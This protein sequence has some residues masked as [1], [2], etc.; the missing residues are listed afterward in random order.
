M[1]GGLKFFPDQASTMAGP[2]DAFFFYLVGVSVFFTVLIFTLVAVFAVKYRRRPGNEQG[3]HIEGSKLLEI[4][5]TVIPL[6][7]VAIMFFW[8]AK[9]YYDQERAPANALDVLVTGK[10]WMWKFQ[11]SNGRREINTLHI[12]ARTPIKL[13]MGSED[14][15]HNVFVPAF[16]VK[17]DVV[18][19]RLT[20]VWFEATKTGS[21]HL[22]CNQ[23]CGKDHSRMVGK[24]I[25]MEPNEFQAWL[26]GDTGLPPVASGELLFNQL[27]CNSCH[28]GEG[29]LRGP[30]L[31]GLHGS[32][33]ALLGGGS[34]IADDDYIRESIVNPAAKIVDGY[35]PIMPT[36]KGL[37]TEEQLMHLVAYVKS[38][39]APS[40]AKAGA[41]ETTSGATLAV[42]AATTA[43]Q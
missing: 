38:L 40:G 1:Q 20:T 24:V 33:V 42:D 8:G 10:K 13:T 21:F 3:A 27:A 11:H 37:V 7:L 32:R 9:L 43:G 15:I 17:Q 26:A 25:V 34:V 16:R 12:P 5:W 41:A 14:V 22:F 29:M 4:T 19:G 28:M 30:S 23:Y 35:Q 2:V 31:A 6:G 18:P 39:E 36:F